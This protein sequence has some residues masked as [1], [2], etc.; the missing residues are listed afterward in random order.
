M[1]SKRW[2]DGRL[3]QPLRRIS[4]W[5]RLAVLLLP[6]LMVV[7]AAE[8]WMTR[9]H[10]VAAAN[11]AYDRSLLGA[12]KALDANIS[13]ESG[14]LAIELPYR[15]F[16][17]FEL[18]ASGPVYF[19][20]ATSDGLVELG[21]ADLPVPP[22]DFAQGVPVF[23]D[24][25]YFGEAVRVAT[26][27]R[28]LAQAPAGSSARTVTVQVAESTRSRADFTRRFVRSAA[29]RD[30]LVLGLLLA[31]SVLA[32]AIALRPLMRLAR[33]VQARSPHDLTPLGDDDLPADVRPLVAAV[34]H[35]MERVQTLMAQQ[36]SFL[37][38]ASHQLRTHLT[39][40]QMQSHYAQRSADESQVRLALQ[41]VQ[42]EL[43]RAT[44]TTQQL[45]ALGRSDAA[46]LQRTPLDLQAL[47]HGV[48][49]GML[50]RARERRIDL[51]IHAA[52][53][54]ARVE[55]DKV[56]LEEALQ[57]LLANAIAHTPA[58]GTVT[59][60]AELAGDAPDAPPSLARL[61]VED[62]GP[63]LSAEERALLGQRF[64][65]GARAGEG[66]SGLG[67]AIARSIAQRHGGRLVLEAR[68][69]GA[70]GLRAVLEWPLQE[71]TP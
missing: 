47:I 12:L 13:T 17:F 4:L 35:Q 56:L 27:R 31:G 9:Q 71:T 14:G 19:R 60:S 43:D 36:R 16:E 38:D 55:G 62:D 10:A 24:A 7:S 25:T 49:V 69:S 65:R 52:G 54:P 70:S 6:L 48:A 21:S 39:T 40:L 18:T 37:D 61:V 15:L 63:G 46:F 59:V 11:S 51:G 2:A 58:D 67:I 30:A 5:R 50:P 45:L 23:Y 41:A 42:V 66:G 28:E 32:L 68:S 20:I 64:R 57:N 8:L 26:Y 34:N 44:R 1:R 22:T 3:L 29:A 33:Q 53:Q